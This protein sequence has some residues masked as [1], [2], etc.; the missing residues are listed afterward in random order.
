MYEGWKGVFN[1]N[2]SMCGEEIKGC[3]I[4]SP[5]IDKT[6]RSM[7]PDCAKKELG[8]NAFFVQ[9]GGDSEVGINDADAHIMFIDNL[10][11]DND[12]NIEMKK[13]LGEFYDVPEHCV[14]TDAEHEKELAFEREME[15]EHYANEGKNEDDN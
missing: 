1:M 8:L 5:T 11:W 15:A 3:V 7:C 4:S 14:K 6:K 10:T 13:L 2:C 9:G 12:M